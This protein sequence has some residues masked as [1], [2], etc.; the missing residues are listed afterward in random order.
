MSAVTQFLRGIS[1]LWPFNICILAVRPLQRHTDIQR[2]IENLSLW[3]KK[4]TWQSLDHLIWWYCLGGDAYRPEYCSGFL[5]NNDWYKRS[6]CEPWVQQW[7]KRA[8]QR[9]HCSLVTHVS[10]DLSQNS[11]CS[12]L[13]SSN[14]GGKLLEVYVTFEMLPFLWNKINSYNIFRM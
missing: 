2:E 14:G 8:L 5:H 1:W 6:F 12:K 11:V 10:G 7:A 3:E 13:I 9:V 4:H